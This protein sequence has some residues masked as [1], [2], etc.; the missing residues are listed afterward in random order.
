M[1]LQCEEIKMFQSIVQSGPYIQN[2]KTDQ[3]MP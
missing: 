3:N 1:N 2:S